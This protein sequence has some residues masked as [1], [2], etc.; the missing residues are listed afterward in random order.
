MKSDRSRGVHASTHASRNA[1]FD[2]QGAQTDSSLSR[3][4]PRSFDAVRNVPS[5]VLHLTS[6]LFRH[7]DHVGRGYV[8]YSEN[9]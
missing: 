4:L 1:R 6:F 5:M 7:C 3:D 2:V 9:F 8:V